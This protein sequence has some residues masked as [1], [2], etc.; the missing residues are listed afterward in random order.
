MDISQLGASGAVVIV[1]ILFLRFMKEE[2]AKR[3]RAYE[4]LSESMDQFAGSNQKIADE[5]GEQTQELRQGNSE[6]KERNGH[7]AELTIQS[8]DMTLE[9]ILNV[10]EQKVEHQTVKRETVES[11]TIQ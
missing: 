10:K 1:V 11:Q 5:L 8:R 9:A 7:L 6:A 2:N 3:D 4:K